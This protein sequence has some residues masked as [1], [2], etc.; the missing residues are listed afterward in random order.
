MSGTALTPLTYSPLNLNFGNVTVG[1]NNGT[2]SVVL[3]NNANS[4]LT[5]AFSASGNYAVAGSG[6]SPCGATLASHAKCT[7]GV[8]FTPSANGTIKGEIAI[9][10]NSVFSPAIVGLSGVGVNGTAGGPLT[11]SV[12]NLSFTKTVVG[13]TSVN[14]TVTVTNSGTSTVAISSI[15]S[16]GDF[17]GAP[18]GGRPCGATLAVSAQCSI[19][20][21][22]S[23]SMVG[24]ITGAVTI[25]DNSSVS[26][27]ILNLT[28]TGVLPVSLAPASVAFP[29][30]TVGTVSANQTITLTNNQS[31]ALALSGIVA[32]GDYMVSTAT[33]NPCGSS[34]PALGSCNIAVAFAPSMTGT[35]TGAVTVSYNAAYSPQPVNLVGTGQ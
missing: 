34:V 7:I 20:V 32:S 33:T 24:T 27:Q 21:N 14:K 25:T 9:A 12:A 2:K 15:A 29:A 28:G 11:F 19:I 3:T 5:L 16:N 35:I 18:G 17:T 31:T 1:T 6:S 30:Q 10:S 8:T 23:P 4:A 13:T 26:P 22:F